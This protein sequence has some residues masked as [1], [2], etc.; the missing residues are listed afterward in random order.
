MLFI[1]CSDQLGTISLGARKWKP[2]T[3]TD[4]LR[5]TKPEAGAG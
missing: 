4:V 2:E 3:L 1:R 5:V